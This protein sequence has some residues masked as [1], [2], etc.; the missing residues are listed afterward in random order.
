MEALIN[1]YFSACPP[2]NAHARPG[3]DRGKET[4]PNFPFFL[5]CKIRTQKDTSIP[6]GPPLILNKILVYFWG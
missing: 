5:A 3:R 2:R 6:L 1:I 4:G